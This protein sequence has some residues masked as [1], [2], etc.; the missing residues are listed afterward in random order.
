MQC[1]LP[2]SFLVAHASSSAA[3]QPAKT[4]TSPTARRKNP[5][6]TKKLMADI[7]TTGATTTRKKVAASSVSNVEVSHAT[8][9]IGGG[10]AAPPAS[11]TDA[12]P[13]SVLAPHLVKG[14][15]QRLV[16]ELLRGNSFLF[17]SVTNKFSR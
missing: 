15:A 4:D 1:K 13:P 12:A 5:P 11:S 8:P 2:H 3:Y 6:G 16:T 17:A 9:R 7:K 14:Y 10:T